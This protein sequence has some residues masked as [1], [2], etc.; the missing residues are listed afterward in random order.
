M[1]RDPILSGGERGRHQADAARAALAAG[2]HEAGLFQ[3]SKMFRDRGQRHRKRLRQLAHSA[4]G[5][6]EARQDRPAAR[7]R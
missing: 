3:D 4:L 1:P 6:R 2:G 7:I 5:S